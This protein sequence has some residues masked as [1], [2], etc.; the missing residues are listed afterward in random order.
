[1]RELPRLVASAPW[2]SLGVFFVFLGI[3]FSGIHS[4]AAVGFALTGFLMMSLQSRQE[5]GK[6][7]AADGS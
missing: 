2:F 1:M 3:V 4:W 6:G 5:S 7:K